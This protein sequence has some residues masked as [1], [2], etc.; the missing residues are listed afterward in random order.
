[1]PL[2]SLNRNA[3]VA[4]SKKCA[5]PKYRN[6]RMFPQEGRRA[7]SMLM[8]GEKRSLVEDRNVSGTMYVISLRRSVQ[9]GREKKSNGSVVYVN[10]EKRRDPF[11]AVGP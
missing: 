2:A 10:R 4:I 6:P 3:F 1:M 9:K 11:S 8:Q 5:V 7:A